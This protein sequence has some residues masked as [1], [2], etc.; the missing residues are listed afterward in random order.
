MNAAPVVERT[1]AVSKIDRTHYLTARQDLFAQYT[2]S[3]TPTRA[4]RRLIR[5]LGTLTDTCVIHGWNMCMAHLPEALRKAASLVAVGGYGR[6]E[7]LPNSDIDLLVLTQTNHLDDTQKSQLGAAIEQW[8]SVLWDMGVTLSHSVRT[9]D[10]CIADALEDLATQTAILE[11]RYLVGEQAIFNAF[12]AGFSRHF[13]LDVFWREK[14]AEMH[15]L[16]SNT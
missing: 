1:P 2:A 13:D 16:P 3:K 7:L 9:I 8:V 15:P 6:M 14:S 12:Y 10:E 5:E 11:G 4:V